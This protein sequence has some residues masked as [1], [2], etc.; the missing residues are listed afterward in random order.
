MDGKQVLNS[1]Y[2]K[3]L[4]REYGLSQEALADA[5]ERKCLRISIATIKRA[6][7]GKA[8][9]YRTTKNL[10]A[11]Y[12]I[13]VNDLIMLPDS[14]EKESA[15]CQ[16][17]L[18]VVALFKASDVEVYSYALARIESYQPLLIEK[19]G[20]YIVAA[21]GRYSSAIQDKNNFAQSKQTLSCM[22][23]LFNEI[24]SR[25]SILSPFCCLVNVTTILCQ[26]SQFFLDKKQ[27]TS[28]IETSHDMPYNTF[29]VSESLR[30]LHLQQFHFTALNDSVEP[31]WWQLDVMNCQ[32][33]G[34]YFVGRDGEL[35][36]V[37][38]QIV[39]SSLTK[40][41]KLIG[42]WGEQGIGKT[43][44]LHQLSETIRQ[45]GLTTG[46]IDIEKNEFNVI[47]DLKQ[48]SADIVFIDNVHLLSEQ[49]M[50]ILHE[51]VVEIAD[52]VLTVIVTA[53]V[54]DK[55]RV[56]RHIQVDASLILPAL[57]A[58]ECRLLVSQYSGSHLPE[59]MAEKIVSKCQGNPLYLSLL[60]SSHDLAM[61]PDTLQLLFEEQLAVL[62]QEDRNV[63][64][65]LAIANKPLRLEDIRALLS[66]KIDISILY[67]THLVI[68]YGVDQLTV[69]HDLIADAL[70][71]SLASSEKLYLH[72]QL[73]EYFE[74]TNIPNNLTGLQ[75]LAE[76]FLAAG[77]DFKAAYYLGRC[78]N[79]QLAEGQY[80]DAEEAIKAAE[81]LLGNLRLKGFDTGT[82]SQA[83][84]VDLELDLMFYLANI[85]K[86]RYGWFS[87]SLIELY[88][89]IIEKCDIS[90][91][92]H[93][94][95]NALFGV[96]TVALTRLDI[97]KAIYYA[98]KAL[99]LA[100]LLDDDA[101]R[102]LSLA[103]LAN[104]SFW[105][106]D[107]QRTYEYSSRALECCDDEL[108]ESSL[109][110]AGHDPRMLAW[111]FKLLS[112]SQLGLENCE[113]MML[114]MV[115]ES[116][117]GGHVFSI[118]IALQGAAWYY[119]HEQNPEKSLQY[120]RE[121]V[122]IS[123]EYGFP[124]YIGM[125]SIIEGWAA[126]QLDPSPRH[127]E[128]L[129]TGYQRWLSSSG[130]CLTQSMYSLLLSQ[131]L[132]DDSQYDLAVKVI[133][134]SVR[135]AS[136]TGAQCYV[137]DMLFLMG[138][139]KNNDEYIS[140]ALAHEACTPLLKRQIEMYEH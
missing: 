93:R 16:E 54:A 133:E 131:V 106:G 25:S 134:Q 113:S 56:Q 13:E 24:K 135:D 50:Q 132:V 18:G 38:R 77:L 119:W 55:A 30:A 9:N 44:F 14:E 46:W 110:L 29:I 65:I 108:R 33:S 137:P 72:R 10:A 128:T 129:V 100:E 32:P 112:A 6:E 116:R 73:A 19:Y 111:C 37:K 76:Q 85:Y 105:A 69:A 26:E 4:R 109:E 115:D 120:A 1:Q 51:A 96:W 66:E 82:V 140:Q 45:D 74:K 39:E 23:D 139:I 123:R 114:D 36:Q 92:E 90:Q 103:A 122:D 75:W 53:T 52:R 49:G 2:L 84:C 27:L 124:F 40:K 3:S 104:T 47:R 57:T 48:G 86:V 22:F 79:L 62:S 83:Q 98:D 94:K 17:R 5:C 7:T 64:K 99:E 8:V 31:D 91:S 89:R 107:A 95:I 121:L 35:E 59:E 127:I 101:G 80:S 12:G 130:F 61:V 21:F 58:S 102:V 117:K 11:F 43:C 70:S 20:T 88:N 68:P 97:D 87:P 28:L 60:L 138:K 63:L 42:I 67:Q 118:A 81:K 126:Y 41:S 71:Q 136:E 34:P 15:T 125:G 78:G